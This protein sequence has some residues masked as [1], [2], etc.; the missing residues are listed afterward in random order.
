MRGFVVGLAAAAAAI[1]ISGCS[2][3]VGSGCS[4]SGSDL[5]G[6]VRSRFNKSLQAQ[7]KPALPPVTCPHDIKNTVGATT[8]CFA[9]GNFGAGQTGTLGIT[10]TVTSVNGSTVNFDFKADQQLQ[11]SG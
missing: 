8:R 9:K 10:V 2:V 5:A 6:I 1:A 7:G 3:C 4:T 11:P